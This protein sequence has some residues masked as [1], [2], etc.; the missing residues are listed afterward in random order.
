MNK[1]NL[2]IRL[3]EFADKYN[4]FPRKMKLS[5]DEEKRFYNTVWMHMKRAR[6]GKCSAESIRDFKDVFPFWDDTLSYRELEKLYFDRKFDTQNLIRGTNIRYR[7]FYVSYD[8][9]GMRKC[10]AADISP[11]MYGKYKSFDEYICGEEYKKRYSFHIIRN[12]E[13]NSGRKSMIKALFPSVKY[14]IFSLYCLMIYSL[15]QDSDF[16]F[17]SWN[18]YHPDRIYNRWFLI[19]LFM[20]R[21]VTC[22]YELVNFED[23]ITDFLNN[24]KSELIEEFE[25]DTFI[26]F[27]EIG[28]V[29]TESHVFNKKKG[30]VIADVIQSLSQNE[31]FLDN[32]LYWCEAEGV[33]PIKFSKVGCKH[34]DK[35]LNWQ[36]VDISEL[37]K[38]IYWKKEK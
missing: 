1:D 10:D 33:E 12:R 36:K 16:R 34:Y 22:I 31:R 21:D 25:I 20:L 38:D 30:Q 23:N 5:S 6:A 17:W 11:I 9:I 19:N 3:K 29:E 14:S 24:Y 4:R 27:Y 35:Y 2:A 26:R 13:N 7:D 32:V 8:L 15:T 28:D 37:G 18:I